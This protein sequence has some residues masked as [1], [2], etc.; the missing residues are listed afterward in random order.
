MGLSLRSSP[1]VPDHPLQANQPIFGREEAFEFI[2][3]QLARFGSV[4]LVGEPRM[5]KTSLLHHLL[6]N[7]RHRPPPG[8]P[9]LCLT[10]VDFQNYVV[11]L[12]GFYGLALREILLCL[13]THPRLA[14]APIRLKRLG[15]DLRS[16]LAEFEHWLLRLKEA[17]IARPVL[18]MDDFE[19]LLEPRFLPGF[20]SPVFYQGLG[21][22]LAGELLALV[23]ASRLPLSEHFLH[24]PEAP[25]SDFPS[26]LST[27]ILREL[28]DSAA[29]QLLAR[30]VAC[31]F[32]PAEIQRARH[33]AGGHPCKLQCAGEA[34]YEAKQGH[35][36]E[37]WAK[38]RFGELAGKLCQARARE[39]WAGVVFR[40][41][42]R[43]LLALV[44]VPGKA[45][46]RVARSG[47][48]LRD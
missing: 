3:G 20:P 25:A 45:W 8:D 2:H 35:E 38:R 42:G 19:R 29:E 14:D 11:D 30:G 13:P 44:A 40:R 48:K 7:P 12:A 27:Y 23:A 1:F 28:D 33:W 36:G 16:D 47:D 17:R 6:D 21:S 43:G 15:E 37:A 31:G 24:H 41:I 39:S 5:G 10:R 34:W 26:H 9:P 46:R 32:Q 18:L 4:N 22:L